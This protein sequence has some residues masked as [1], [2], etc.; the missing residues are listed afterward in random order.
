M[1]Q[2]DDT[3]LIQ[4]PTTYDIPN[5]HILYLGT[6]NKHMANTFRST[7]RKIKRCNLMRSRQLQMDLVMASEMMFSF[8][9]IAPA[10]ELFDC[11]VAI[12]EFDTFRGTR[13]VIGNPHLRC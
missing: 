4:A 13:H 7:F 3:Y 2:F 11:S 8:Y 10:F 12:W 5:I 6:V 1:K 9:N